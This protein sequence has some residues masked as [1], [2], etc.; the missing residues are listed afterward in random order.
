MFLANQKAQ[1]PSTWVYKPVA[2]LEAE[3]AGFDNFSQLGCRWTSSSAASTEDSSA[4][5]LTAV[6]EDGTST[7]DSGSSKTS[8][9]F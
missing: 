1:T 3:K 5:A 9:L 7:A 8:M 4:S 6:A 2:L